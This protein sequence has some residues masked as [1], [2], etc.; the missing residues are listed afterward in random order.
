MT[1]SVAAHIAALTTFTSAAR[2]Q[3]WPFCSCSQR[4]MVRLEPSQMP[5]VH[6]ECW[7]ESPLAPM[8]QIVGR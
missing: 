1:V 7:L 8:A 4:A 5:Q 6:S 3:R 2:V